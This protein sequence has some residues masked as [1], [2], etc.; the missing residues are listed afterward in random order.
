MTENIFAWGLSSAQMA[1][2]LPGVT[3]PGTKAGGILA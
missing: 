3:Q 2:G 1:K